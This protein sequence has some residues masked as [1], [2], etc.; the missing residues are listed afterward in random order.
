MVDFILSLPT[1]MMIRVLG[2]ASFLLL[3]AGISLGISYS[4]PFQK[5][6]TKKNVY[7]IHSFATISGTA[8]GLLHGAITIIDTYA[9]YSWSGLFVPFSAQV[10]PA[11]SGFGTL[12]SYGLLV[13]ILTTDLRNKLKRRVWLMLHMLSYPIYIMALIH[14]FFLGTDSS[15]PLIRLMYLCSMLLILGLTAARFRVSAEN[16]R[17]TAAPAAKQHRLYVVPS[18]QELRENN[19]D[20]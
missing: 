6:N 13:V 14:S 17:T 3:T 7:R 1:W 18:A 15:L 19:R 9:P 2:I 10:S 16:K 8:L 5:R 4:F 11:L 12:S 20:A